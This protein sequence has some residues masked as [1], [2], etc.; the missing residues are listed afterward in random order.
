MPAT[1]GVVPCSAILFKSAMLDLLRHLRLI[2]D[3]SSILAAVFGYDR[4]DRSSPA[5]IRGKVTVFRDSGFED[6]LLLHLP[7]RSVYTKAQ[8]R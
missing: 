3:H 8:R 6:Q 2:Q 1:S 5:V 7:S 4:M